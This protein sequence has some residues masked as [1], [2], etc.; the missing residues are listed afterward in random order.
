MTDVMRQDVPTPVAEG[1]AFR[2]FRP[3]E[4]TSELVLGRTIVSLLDD[5]VERN[6]NQKAFNQ[7]RDGEWISLSTADFRS[8]AEALALGFGAIG[9]NKGDRVAFF[10]KNDVSFTLPDMACLMAGLV[11]VPIYLTHAAGNIRHILVES[12]ARVL[13]VSD[14]ELLA[15]V[16]PT[17][18]ET[19]VNMVVVM[20]GEAPDE[21]VPGVAAVV[22]GDL[23]SRGRAVATSDPGAVRALREGLSPHELAT[24]IYTSGT[25]GVPKG[26][27]LTH[28]NI[29]SN[30]IA[31]FTGLAGYGRGPDET[32]LSFLPLSHIFAR[33][34]QY[35]CMWYGNTVYYS[36]PD[37]LREH[38]REIRPTM[39]ATVPRVLE[40]AYE[41]IMGVGS[42]LHGLKRAIFDWS[43][44]LARR[45]RVDAQPQGS[46]AMKLKLADRLVL[47]K[48][49][50][51]LG[52]RMRNVIV[53]AAPL[54]SELVNLFGAAGVNVLQGYGL[55]ETSPVISFNRPDNNRPGTVGTPIA[56]AEVTTSEDG[57]ILTR[58]PHVMLGYYKRQDATDEVLR[59]G[60]FHTGDLGRIDDEGFITITGRKKNL[61]KLSTG[62]YVMPQPVEQQLEAEALVEHAVVLGEGE[63]YC[64]ALLFLNREALM[65]LFP[66][67]NVEA[68]E[69]LPEPA[70]HEAVRNSLRR[71][72]AGLPGWSCVK[73]AVL[74]VG[75]ASTEN[76][77]LTPTLKLRREPALAAYREAIESLYRPA[78]AEPEGVVVIEV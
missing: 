4:G 40:K 10:A 51:A 21:T 3:D 36:D 75:E 56:G 16:A 44:G 2:S 66:Q 42:E 38:F 22:A 73:R 15:K 63:K 62:K 43:L 7:L 17:L 72:N 54:R 13:V 55:T 71:A 65:A 74:T 53:G 11:T 1:A 61:F 19:G 68:R 30:A 9:M 77:L 24:I 45:Y 32:V 37:R 78:G 67:R 60:W 58:G 39:M 31:S 25:T 20:E 52:G 57:E 33:T 23:M 59:D 28:Q 18:P 47:S 29:S 6:P 34:L 50:E 69:L 5:A 35:G 8:Q 49:R 41:R 12:E 46:E 26:V 14:A 27:M 70:L 64:A 76:E 48:W